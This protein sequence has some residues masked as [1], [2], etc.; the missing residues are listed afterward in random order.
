MTCF[1]R[2]SIH[3]GKKVV[4]RRFFVLTISP[5]FLLRTIRRF[6]TGGLYLLSSPGFWIS[7]QWH[8]WRLFSRSWN[9]FLHIVKRN[10]SHFDSIVGKLSSTSLVPLSV[11]NKESYPWCIL[12]FSRPSIDGPQTVMRNSQFRIKYLSVHIYLYYIMMMLRAS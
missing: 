4:S 5:L 11:V 3:H 6:C 8:K 10:S 2:P 1:S 12:K 7:H 9:F